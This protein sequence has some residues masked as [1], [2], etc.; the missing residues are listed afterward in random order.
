L[1]REEE[2]GSDAQK[3]Y[4][5]WSELKNVIHSKMERNRKVF[6]GGCRKRRKKKHRQ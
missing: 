6:A 5:G 1:A 4:T 2:K 3:K